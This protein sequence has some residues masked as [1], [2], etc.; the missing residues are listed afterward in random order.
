MLRPER[1]RRWRHW[2]LAPGV[3]RIGDPAEGPELAV[4][5]TIEDGRAMRMS[6]SAVPL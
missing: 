4:F 6:I 3:F 1:W 5:D 2:T